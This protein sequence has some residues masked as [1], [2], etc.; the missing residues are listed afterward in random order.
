MLIHFCKGLMGQTSRKSD[1]A[2]KHE[3]IKRDFS[4]T[5]KCIGNVR[6]YLMLVHAFSECDTTSDV[7]EQGRL[8]ILK[9]LKK[10]K[11][12]R[13]EAYVF[14]PKDRTP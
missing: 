14:S 3:V 13:E 4:N 11:A 5:A 2:A 7:Y 8:S 12:E 1:T 10:S 6:K 9:L